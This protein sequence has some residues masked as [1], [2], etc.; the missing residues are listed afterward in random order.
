MNAEILSV[1][2]LEF[3]T[4]SAYSLPFENDFMD[5]ATC[6]FMLHHLEDVK[7]ALFEIK[8]VLKKSGVLTAVEPLEHQHHHGP[9]LSE[10][11]WKE[12]FEDA[13]FYVETESLEGAAVLKAKKVE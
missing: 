11:G 6:F 3:S 8:R 10:I 5:A 12:M 4:G 1:T 9:Q 13:G 2:N 7:F